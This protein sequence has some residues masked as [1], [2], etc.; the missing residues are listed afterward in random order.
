MQE[1][2]QSHEEGNMLK[3]LQDGGGAGDSECQSPPRR[4][5][6]KGLWEVGEPSTHPRRSARISARYNQVRNSPFL[7]AGTFSASVSDG[8]IAK[9]NSRFRDPEIRM[10]PVK[11]WDLGKHMGIACRGVEEEAVQEMQCMELRDEEFMQRFEEGVKKG[12]LC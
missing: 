11:L 5:R 12:F 8:E 2:E 9:C 1:L 6:M 4:S 7:K 10:E 3:G